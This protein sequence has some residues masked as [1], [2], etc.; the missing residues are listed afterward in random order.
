MK[1]RICVNE[2]KRILLC[3]NLTIKI[4]MTRY[5]IYGIVYVCWRGSK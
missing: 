5:I 3:Y 1:M 4:E 2:N